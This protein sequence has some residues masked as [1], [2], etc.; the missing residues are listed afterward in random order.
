MTAAA[1]TSNTGFMPLFLFQRVRFGPGTNAPRAASLHGLR[2]QSIR[3]NADVGNVYS[4]GN[5][6]ET[7]QRYG[8]AM[9]SSISRILN[10]WKARR[11]ELQRRVDELRQRDGETCRRCRRPMRFDLPADHDS[12]PA[13]VQLGGDSACLCHRRCNARTVDNTVEV[14][15]RMKLRLEAAAVAETRKCSRRPRKRAA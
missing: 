7:L 3:K 15:E 13:L 6:S 5:S 11:A 9:A 10:P 12:A 2:W 14:Q 4:R 8:Q 1:A